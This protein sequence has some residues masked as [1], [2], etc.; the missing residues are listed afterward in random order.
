MSLIQ[1][2]FPKEAGASSLTTSSVF[3]WLA[4]T[5]LWPFYPLVWG[6]VICLVALCAHNSH[7]PWFSAATSVHPHF[8]KRMMTNS[9]SFHLYSPSVWET[10]VLPLKPFTFIF[11]FGGLCLPFYIVH[12]KAFLLGLCVLTFPAAHQ[13]RMH[14]ITKMSCADSSG[15]SLSW[16]EMP[17]DEMLGRR[18]DTVQGGHCIH[19]VSRHY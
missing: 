4:C 18:L 12:L 11:H 17:L 10:P 19:S 6:Y 16:F 13:V 5:A 2:G 7:Y 3:L 15:L 14:F 9:V 1:K 8:I